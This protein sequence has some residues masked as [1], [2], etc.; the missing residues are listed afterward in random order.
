MATSNPLDS[1]YS[2]EGRPV[3]HKKQDGALLLK[4]DG[5]CRF[6][7]P[8]ERLRAWWW[9]VRMAVLIAQVEETS[10]KAAWAQAHRWWWQDYREW[11]LSP[12]DAMLEAYLGNPPTK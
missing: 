10:F 4:R 2:A 8:L 7:T 12:R 1:H 5:S 9:A 6:L 11:G 3:I